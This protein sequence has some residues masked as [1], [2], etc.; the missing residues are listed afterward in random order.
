[1]GPYRSTGDG[2]FLGVFHGQID[3][4]LG[5]ADRYSGGPEESPADDALPDNLDSTAVDSHEIANRNPAV[6]EKHRAGR[7]ASK[8]HLVFRLSKRQAAS[9]SFNKKRAHPF[10]PLFRVCPDEYQVDIS[11]AR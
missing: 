9:V 4:C 10:G 2:P 7:G 6:V 5:D 11:F 1:M 3:G 8:A